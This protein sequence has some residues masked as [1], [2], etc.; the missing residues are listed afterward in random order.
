MLRG[1]DYSRKLGSDNFLYRLVNSAIL[2]GAGWRFCIYS[3]RFFGRSIRMDN[4][5]WAKLT[6]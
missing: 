1:D 6:G 4:L 3:E 2:R 5:W